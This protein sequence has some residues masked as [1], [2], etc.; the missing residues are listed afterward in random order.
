MIG[1]KKFNTIGTY[2]KNLGFKDRMA[3]SPENQ[4][5]LRWHT[6]SDGDGTTSA[7]EEYMQ[8]YLIVQREEG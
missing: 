6:C 5:G 8:R 7:S 3:G 4:V 1:K 2:L